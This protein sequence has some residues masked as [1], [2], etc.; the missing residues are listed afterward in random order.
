MQ[1]CSAVILSYLYNPL[2]LFTSS[3][4]PHLSPVFR[5]K[6]K[7]HCHCLLAKSKYKSLAYLHCL[8][9]LS[10]HSSVKPL[11]SGF[12]LHS[13]IK[14]LFSKVSSD[15]HEAKWSVLMLLPA[16]PVSNTR[17]SWSLSIHY[18]SKTMHI[19]D[20]LFNGFSLSLFFF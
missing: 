10:S 2:N 9:F 16:W 13:P 7:R 19:P 12:N 1:I 11:Q 14:L 17:L 6:H 8:K 5:V 4:Q 15:V 18:T 3:H 20:F